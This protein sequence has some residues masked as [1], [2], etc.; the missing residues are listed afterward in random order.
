MGHT[1][2]GEKGTRL[3]KVQSNLVSKGDQIGEP[4][5]EESNYWE[6]QN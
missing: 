3:Y 5:P 1:L 6:D 4:Y 2:R